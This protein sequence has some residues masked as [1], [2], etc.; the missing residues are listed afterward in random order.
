[1]QSNNFTISLPD[2]RDCDIFI[3]RNRRAKRLSMRI[4]TNPLMVNVTQPAFCSDKHV[5]QFIENQQ[6]WIMRHLPQSMRIEDEGFFLFR[7]KEYHIRLVP[8]ETISN[9]WLDQQYIYSN[10][11]PII[12]ADRLKRWLKQQAKAH[13]PAR[14]HY[15][16]EKIDR[17]PSKITLTDHNGQWGRCNSKQEIT[18]NW[19]LM[20]APEHVSDYVAA[21]EA[22]HLAQM[23]HS[24]AFWD[25][26]DQLIDNKAEAQT[27]LKKN[28]LYIKSW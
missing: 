12:L 10:A 27:W 15:Y 1:M 9:I 19:R 25:V 28:G 22:A 4:S 26:V 16:A 23:N 18:I 13:L 5:R 20:M 8:S 24:K 21:H 3:K 6:D 7:G 11:E 14:I 2:S 17:H